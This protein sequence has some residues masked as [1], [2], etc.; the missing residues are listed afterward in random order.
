MSRPVANLVL[1]LAGAIWGM[2]FIAQSTAMDALG[3]LTFIGLRFLVATAFIAPFAWYETRRATAPVGK[4][5]LKGFGLIGLALFGGMALQQYGLVITSVTNAGFLTGLYVVIVPI[6]S[7]L[8][9]RIAPHPVV[10]PA[11]ALSFI[12]IWLLAGGDLVALNAG[13]MLT[14]ACAFLWS[15]QVLLVGRYSSGS[16]RPITL[17]FVQFAVCAALG[18]LAAVLVENIR[19]SD[20]VTALPEI[21]FAGIFASGV[22]FTLQVVGQ[23]YTTAPQAAIF[24][25]TE[26]LFAAIFGAILL[27]ERIAPIGYLGGILIFIAILLVEVGPVLLRRARRGRIQEF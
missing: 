15:I 26:A 12:G 2:G 10:W 3:P 19:L 18:L 4:G 7:F 27:G 11:V 20:I 14:I 23:R 25:S 24:L 13:D 8:V 21:L 5:N 17:S 9:L 22:A 16:G 6:L 1:L